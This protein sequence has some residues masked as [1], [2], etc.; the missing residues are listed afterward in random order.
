MADQ[1]LTHRAISC[2]R[3]SVPRR[4]LFGFGRRKGS[5]TPAADNPVYDDFLK[6]KPPPP[7]LVRGDLASS[8]IFESEDAARKPAGA[9]GPANDDAPPRDP[10]VMAAVLDPQPLVR[11]RW[12][13]K[14]VIRDIRKRGRLSRTAMI[15]RT[16][17]E[18]L[19][20]SHF[21]KTSVKKLAP[22][23]RQIA[24]KSV[25]DALL[26][27]RF[28][29]KK[30]AKE[31]KKHLEHARDEAI[32]RRGM[33]LGGTTGVTGSPVPIVTKEGRKKMV[34]DRTELYIDQAWVGRGTFGK[35]PEHRA[36]GKINILRPPTTSITVLLKEEATRIRHHEE[37]EEKRRN[38]KLWLPLPNRPIT[39]QRP[40]YSW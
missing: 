34:R 35:E 1:I 14:M 40:Y 23:A 10:T 12:E 39:A 7:R 36:R 2:A 20:K 3:Q 4:S 27:M 25:D 22:I 19:S 30:A 16:E 9:P 5:G 31:V 11:R 15:K 6:K 8:S 32:V 37:R 33:S 17:R 24:G 18:S 29:K 28:S 38:R 26:Q 21:L 13:R